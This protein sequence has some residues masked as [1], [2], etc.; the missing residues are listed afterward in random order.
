MK[1]RLRLESA[2]AV[3]G[4]DAERQGPE[5]F[6][7]L[8]GV[9]YP[10]PQSERAA[11]RIEPADDVVEIRQPTFV[12]LEQ[13]LDESIGSRHFL[14]DHGLPQRLDVTSLSLRLPGTARRNHTVAL[15]AQAG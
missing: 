15:H 10:Q 11:R 1:L 2:P 12:H 5:A 13:Q 14:D 3:E 7:P 6:G 8:N 4:A 9:R